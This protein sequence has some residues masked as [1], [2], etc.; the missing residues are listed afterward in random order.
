MKSL[1]VNSEQYGSLLIPVIMAKLPSDVRMQVARCTKQDVWK[2]HA[3]LDIILKE[4][5]A[6]EISDS[7]KVSDSEPRK[8]RILSA[9]ALAAKESQERLLHVFI[10]EITITLP[11]V[12]E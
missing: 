5:E 3:L 2:I 11:H 12:T 8:P 9:A 1:G 6:R 7:V 4:V 10:V